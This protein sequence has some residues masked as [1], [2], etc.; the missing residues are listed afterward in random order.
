MKNIKRQKEFTISY[1]LQEL[2]V[3]MCA[4]VQFHSRKIK[5]LIEHKT[6]NNDE[7][8]QR[9]ETYCSITETLIL[10]CQDAMDG[11]ELL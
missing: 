11:Q 7:L 9:A 5:D 1:D 6:N 8:A 3:N 2:I 4:L 10:R